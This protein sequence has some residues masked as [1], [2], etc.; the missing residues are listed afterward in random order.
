MIASWQI[1]WI[2]FLPLFLI[3]LLVEFMLSLLIIF[4]L[5]DSFVDKTILPCTQVALFFLFSYKPNTSISQ[6]F[7]VPFSWKHNFH[8]LSSCDN[9]IIHNNLQLK[10][11]FGILLKIRFCSLFFHL[12]FPIYI[13]PRQIVPW[14]SLLRNKIIWI[15]FSQLECILSI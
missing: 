8:S 7:H 6:T 5:Q 2:I 11:P 4:A 10:L 3:F 12:I 1:G 9:Q 15:R 14:I 13:L